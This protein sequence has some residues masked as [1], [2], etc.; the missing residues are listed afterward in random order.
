M[1]NAAKLTL[2]T[3]GAYSYRPALKG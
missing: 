3:G 2:E 1:K